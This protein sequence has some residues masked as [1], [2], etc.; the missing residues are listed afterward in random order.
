MHI[1][2]RSF[3]QSAPTH[4]HHRGRRGPG[5]GDY[6]GTGLPQETPVVLVYA[7][8]GGVY[9]SVAIIWLW[10]VDAVRPTP[11]DIAGVLI[12]LTGMAV[13]MLGAHHV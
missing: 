9:V 2:S 10:L 12:C 7:A 11:W 4:E 6:W 3:R 1:L 13:I 8:Y 5:F